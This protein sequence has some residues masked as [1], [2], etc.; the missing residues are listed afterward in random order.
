MAKVALL[1]DRTFDERQLQAV[2]D[3]LRDAGEEV[4]VV[5]PRAGE[6]VH[7]AEGRVHVT[8]DLSVDD[9]H[10]E[11][12][13]ALVIPGGF[14]RNHLRTHERML[15][16]IRD[17]YALGK[18]VG[19]MRDPGWMLIPSDSHSHQLMTWPRIKRDLIVERELSLQEAEEAGIILSG[20]PDPISFAD[21]VLTQLGR[22]PQG[23]APRAFKPEVAEDEVTRAYGPS[24]APATE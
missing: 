17:V 22:A 20:D 23:E 5:G 10:A 15:N 9:V 8:V 11:D 24:P 7:G 12:F 3:R 21:A 18:P 14:R 4:V 6:S 13:D 2:M 16:F 19:V 1:I